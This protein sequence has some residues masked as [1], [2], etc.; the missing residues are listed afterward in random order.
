MKI[1]FD[2][3]GTF[4]TAKGK[5][6]AQSLADTNTIYIISARESKEGINGDFVPR[7]RIYATGS[8]DAKVAKVKELG[9]GRHYDNNP[10]VVNALGQIG[11]LFNS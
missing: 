7:S 1:S 4:S 10:D 2:Y 3:D 11:V 5:D 9:I 6:L 8:N